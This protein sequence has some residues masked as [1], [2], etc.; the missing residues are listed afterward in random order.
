ME[1][2][3]QRYWQALRELLDRAVADEAAELAAAERMLAETPPEPGSHFSDERIAEVVRLV[4]EADTAIAVVD[5]RDDTLELVRRAAPTERS[6]EAWQVVGERSTPRAVA[7]TPQAKSALP[8]R[9]GTVVPLATAR[10]TWR[11]R[12]AKL[13]RPLAAAAMILLAPQFIAAMAV[14]SV[15]VVVSQLLT[16]TSSTLSFEQ[17]AEMTV[18]PELPEGSRLSSQQVVAA[19][20]IESIDI[21]Y[22]AANEAAP[23]GP[24]AT[25]ALAEIR[26]SASQPEQFVARKFAQGHI[27]VGNQLETVSN[28]FEL[29]SAALEQLLAQIKYGLSALSAVAQSTTSA[30]LR[31]DNALI[32][33]K[34][35]HQLSK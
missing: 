26:L 6:V 22:S 15:V 34:L 16:Y 18:D 19:N 14:V 25:Q 13:P 32:L 20:L 23:L 31:R 8:P 35:T 33:V 4:T 1:L 7:S 27:E 2:N 3:E 17:A 30:Q 10:Q 9:S 29:R 24:L 5:D 28:G 21:L 12:V 11:Q